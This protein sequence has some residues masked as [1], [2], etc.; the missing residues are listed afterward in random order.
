MDGRSEDQESA[1]M[2]R[3]V[4]PA[5]R[6]RQLDRMITRAKTQLVAERRMLRTE[7]RAE[8]WTWDKIAAVSGVSIAAI[9]KDVGQANR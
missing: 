8:G 3:T 1:R 5:G 6:I 4:T 7:L 2:A 9:Q